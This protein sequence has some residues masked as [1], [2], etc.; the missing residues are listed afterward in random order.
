MNILGKWPTCH[1][2]L[3]PKL[4]FSFLFQKLSFINFVFPCMM[5]QDQ[6]AMSTKQYMGWYSEQGD[7]Y[8][9]LNQLMFQRKFIR[10][11]I[12]W[13]PIKI[14]LGKLNI[15][16]LLSKNIFK[17]VKLKEFFCNYILILWSTLFLLDFNIQGIFKKFPHFFLTSFI[18]NF[19]SKLRHFSI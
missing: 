13:N 9:S 19:K 17:S 11:N 4:Q 1:I 18:K 16:D 3:Y 7:I 12:Y 14:F 8:L 10:L 2:Y 6:D 5:L 15:L